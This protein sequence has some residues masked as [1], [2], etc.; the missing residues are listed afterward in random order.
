MTKDVTLKRV[1]RFKTQSNRYFSPFSGCRPLTLEK[2]PEA[3][4]RI[5][6]LM[7]ALKVW[8]QP[9]NLEERRKVARFA[10]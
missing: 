1:Q 6:K 10:Q 2:K 8:R 7:Q 4:H 9:I 5:F 3:V